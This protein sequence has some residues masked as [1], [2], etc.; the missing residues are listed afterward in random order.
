M[1]VVVCQCPHMWHPV[2]LHNLSPLPSLLCLFE[3]LLQGLFHRVFNL[4]SLTSK[5]TPL[6]TSQRL[7][8]TV[9][10]G[11]QIL[12]FVSSMHKL[13]ATYQHLTLTW[14][15]ARFTTV[16]VFSWLGETMS[17]R[18]LL[19]VVPSSLRWAD[20]ET[21]HCPPAHANHYLGPTVCVF[22]GVCVC[23]FSGSNSI[24][25]V[26]AGLDASVFITM[27]PCFRV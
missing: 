15:W 8:N 3:V 14:G 13:S 23:L 9:C 11:S 22:V 18:M 17:V 12:H 24:T 2:F 4:F 7:K 20:S 21:L 1:E 27:I 16:P 25:V 26:S 5:V 19:R 10:S 6:I